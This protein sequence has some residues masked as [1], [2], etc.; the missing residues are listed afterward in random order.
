[1]FDIRSLA[2]LNSED[3]HR[4]VTGY[5]SDAKYQISKTES[6]REFALA[7]DLVSLP[8]L[9]RKRFDHLNAETLEH[10]QHVAAFGFSFGAYAAEQCV[11]I[12]LAEPRFWNRSLWVWELDVA[13]TYRRRG[14]GWQLVNALA[15]KA[16]VA[17]LRT[18]VCET[19]NTNMPAIRF[20]R[21]VGFQ[22]EGIDLSYYSND[23]FPDGE[24]ALFMKKRLTP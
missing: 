8:Q 21:R 12:A 20:Y 11:G 2:Q 3:L 24:I 9:Y 1:M 17:G 14:V 23:N 16:R 7:Q 19:Q 6:D 15:E 5:T 4:L 22:I 13:E 10:Y 18:L